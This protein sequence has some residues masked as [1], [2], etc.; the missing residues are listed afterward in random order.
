VERERGGCGCCLSCSECKENKQNKCGSRVA[1]EVGGERLLKLYLHLRIIRQLYDAYLLLRTTM[2]TE[3]AP[4]G[5][6]LGGVRGAEVM[7][8]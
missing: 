6:G 4:L 2:G 5:L 7:A 1:Q 8:F 3:D